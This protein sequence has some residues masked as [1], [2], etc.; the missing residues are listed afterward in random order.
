MKKSIKLL[1]ILL[2]TSNRLI[3]FGCCEEQYNHVWTAESPIIESDS[4]FGYQLQIDGEYVITCEPNAEVGDISGAG[5]IFVYDFEGKLITTHQSPEP[6]IK[7]VFGYR[8]GVH[9]GLLVAYEIENVDGVKNAGKIHVYDML[10]D[11]L[12]TILPSDPVI[13]NLFGYNN[14]VGEEIILIHDVGKDLSPIWAGK[15]HIY[16][17]EGEFI[18]TIT[19]PDPKQ[20]GYFGLSMKIGASQLYLAQYGYGGVESVGPGYVYVYDHQGIHL[21]TIE[22]PEPEELAAFG[23]AISVSDDMLVIGELQ[24]TVDGHEEAG[25]VHIYNTEGEYLRTLLPPNPYTN[26][27]FGVDVAISGNTIVVGEYQ[28]H[29]NPPLR[30]GMAYVFD[31]DGTLLQTLTA[32]DPSPRGAFGMAVDIQD[33]VI[34]IG[35][36]WA[37]V[38]GK[39]DCGRLHVY[40]LGA[41][42]KTQ[43]PIEEEP[44]PVTDDPEPD[45]K[46]GIPGF[47]IWSIVVST[48]LIS[49]ILKHKVLPSQQIRMLQ[50]I[51]SQVQWE[52]E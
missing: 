41:P 8:F 6:G 49:L 26:A 5:K 1:L 12:Y 47:P 30:E 9:D 50:Y 3:P 15:V 36:S 40:K 7:N 4:W 16:D 23:N 19:S 44:T 22:A 32:P 34:V 31:V 43:D 35:E 24:A 21:N 11:R 46:G 28:G 18:K 17:H 48:I 51:D 25:K 27:R 39:T 42:E 29:I 14:A 33:D 20:I 38:E 2:I 52:A 45:P 37:E 10:D 13:N